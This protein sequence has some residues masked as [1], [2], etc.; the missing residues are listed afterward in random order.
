MARSH[1]LSK[2]TF[3]KLLT[4]GLS[5][6]AVILL[7]FI[8]VSITARVCVDRGKNLEKQG[9][10]NDAI[11]SY[12]QATKI[13]SSYLYAHVLLG[14]ALRKKGKFDEAIA[15][16]NKAIL[17]DH[18]YVYAHQSLGDA[19][20]QQGKIDSAIAAYENAINI[21]PKDAISYSLL[22]RALYDRNKIDS[23]I[24]AYKKAIELDP[25]IAT[26]Y[27]NLSLALNKQ[28]KL[29][30]AIAAYKKAIELDPKLANKHKKLGEA[31]AY[32]KK[33]D[34][35]LTTYRQAIKRNP[36]DAS[37]Y[38]NFAQA[39]YEQEKLDK[40]IAAYRQAIKLNPK[41]V[42]AY[43]NLGDA[44]TEKGKLDSAIA[45]YRQTIKLNPSS[46]SAYNNLGNA[47][48]N[49]GKLKSAIAAYRQSIKINDKNASAHNNLGFVLQ[50]QGKFKEA[51]KEFSLAIQLDQIWKTPKINLNETQRFVYLRNNPDT[52]AGSERLPSKNKEP[53]VSLKRSIVRIILKTHSNYRTGAG[54][55][56][57]REGNTAW[58]VT[59]RHVVTDK[60]ERQYQKIEVE[61]YSEP[62][63]GQFR[64]RRPAEITKIS[65]AEDQLDLALLKVTEIPKDIKPLP[66]SSIAISPGT[67]VTIIGHPIT[68]NDWA[69]IK[70]RIRNNIDG[71]L[72]L[73]TIVTGGH[74][75]SPVLDQNNRVVGIVWAGKLLDRTTT[76]PDKP[77]YGIAFPMKPVIEQLQSWGID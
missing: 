55:V 18:N 27:I 65:K 60:N 25:K 70:G 2:K 71:E 33:Q 28:D 46:A 4:L 66:I 50:Q 8:A 45:A 51:I 43:N 74:F 23:A 39:L 37:A 58:L 12:R 38:N 64:K 57:K 34:A 67:P 3:L 61:F 69:A 19:L 56:V 44:L 35:A 10:L 48:R 31:L 72:Q 5:L 62:R 30:S 76:A 26:N 53:L 21:N 36:K 6:Y 15:A 11:A 68:G 42:S 1:K 32:D 49:D 52:L 16:Y 47:L 75:G 17:I 73:S 77:G 22:G 59:N 14:D 9:K 20:K 41:Y 7:P 24:A 13:N 29:D 54:W 40:A 63:P